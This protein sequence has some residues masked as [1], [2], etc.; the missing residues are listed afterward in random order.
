[1]RN[2]IRAEG[3]EIGSWERGSHKDGKLYTK[4][5]AFARVASNC[6]LGVATCKTVLTFKYGYC[7]FDRY[8][9]SRMT[10]RSTQ[11]RQTLDIVPALHIQ[12]LKVNVLDICISEIVIIYMKAQNKMLLAGTARRHR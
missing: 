12:S 4:S 3:E 11:P 9:V 1:M 6:I 8:L 10:N 2:T 5:T 7:S